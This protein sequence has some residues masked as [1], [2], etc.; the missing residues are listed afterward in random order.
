MH[1][2]G[3]FPNREVLAVS[4]LEEDVLAGRPVSGKVRL[5]GLINKALGPAESKRK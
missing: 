3:D 4:Q 2:C 5:K 1:L